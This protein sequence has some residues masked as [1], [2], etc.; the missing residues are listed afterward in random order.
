MKPP[1]EPKPVSVRASAPPLRLRRPER[2][3]AWQSLAIRALL[4][5]ALIGVALVG[6]WSDREGLRDNTDGEISFIDVVYFTMI[7]V[8]TVG[9]G[10]IVPVTERARLFDTFVVTPVRLFVWLIFLGT[11]YD[12]VLRRTWERWRMQLTQKELCDHTVICGFGASGSAAVAELLRKGVAPNRIVAVDIDEERVQAAIGCGVFALQGDATRNATLEAARIE[13]SR[14]LIVSPGR[15]DTTALIVL[16]ARQL[17]PTVHISASVKAD[18]NEDLVRQAGADTVINPINFGGHLLAQSST[19]R[20]VVDYIHDLSTAGGR[21][22][23]REREVTIAEAG[24]PLTALATGLGLRIY[25]GTH[26][27]GFWE[28]EA[29]RLENGDIVVEVVP[30]VGTESRPT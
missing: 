6:H 4:V 10:D 8:T 13:V 7:T 19:G 28:P 11:A 26:V 16:T 15:D 3:S 20:H 27:Y 17:S 22:L 30:Q 29:Q 12:F 23:L 18:E 25:R 5:L 1:F 14:S 9:Y 21:V 24:Q 2:L